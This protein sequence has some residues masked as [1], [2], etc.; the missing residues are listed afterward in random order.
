MT[1]NHSKNP[2]TTTDRD[3]LFHL[4]CVPSEAGD[5]ALATG[6]VSCSREN[7]GALAGLMEISQP[8]AEHDLGDLG[9]T[10][11]Q[12][13]RGLDIASRLLDRQQL[14]DEAGKTRSINSVL[15]GPRGV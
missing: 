3:L 8:G 1:E 4:F 13:G 11:A 12:I 5:V 15:D 7:L 9:A 2:R 14:A 6:I 10:V